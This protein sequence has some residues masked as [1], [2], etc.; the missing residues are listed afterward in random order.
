[1]I[2]QRSYQ[3]GP[4]TETLAFQRLKKSAVPTRRSARARQMKRFLHQ[5]LQSPRSLKEA[6]LLLVGSAPCHPLRSAQPAARQSTSL[7]LGLTS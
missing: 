4:T 2:P 5:F 3:P 7:L 1:M 6:K